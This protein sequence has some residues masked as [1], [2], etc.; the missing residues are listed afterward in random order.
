MYKAGGYAYISSADDFISGN[1]CRLQVWFKDALGSALNNDPTYESFKMY[2]LA[3]TNADMMYSN[4]DVSSPNYGQMG[5]HAQ[6]PRDQWVYLTVSNAVNNSNIGLEDDL[7]TNTVPGVFMMPLDAAQ[8]NVQAYEYSPV[9]A[10]VPTPEYPGVGADSV[11]WDE[12]RLIQVVPVTDLIASVSSGN[13]NLRF[14]AGAGLNYAIQY[15]TNLTDATWRV[16]TDN[17]TA[18]ESWATNPAST[19]I[20]YPVTVSDRVTAHS[21]FYRVQ[22]H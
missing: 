10:D 15:K 8:I 19:G 17:V 22:A 6:L 4:I 11:Y 5:Y 21:R 9:A 2:G 16:L 1:T 3:Y 20:T 12:M 18:P 7:P 13:I 14:S